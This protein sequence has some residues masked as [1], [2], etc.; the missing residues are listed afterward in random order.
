MR[1][2][3]LPHLVARPSL[4]SAVGLASIT[5]NVSRIIGPALGAWLL[6]SVSTAAA[7]LLVS[8]LFGIGCLFL[9]RLR[10]RVQRSSQPKESIWGALS[11]GLV[12]I[13]RSPI[14]RL[15]L[16]LTTIDG[17]IGRS[18]MELLPA[19]SGQ[20]I[21]G[22]AGTLASLSAVAGLG[23]VL[24]GL[25][26][27]RMRGRERT[28]LQLVFGSLLLCSVVV[29]LVPWVQGGLGLGSM[30][31][32]VSMAVT[33]TGTGCQALIQGSVADAFRG[34]VLSIWTVVSLGIPAL[35]ALVIGSVAEAVGFPLVLVI[36]ALAAGALV[37]LLL[38]RCWATMVLRK[39]SMASEAAG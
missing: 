15:V 21:N 10:V 39:D 17:L 4:P 11:G 34:R 29:L 2:V 16:I 27:S 6:V 5:Y 31:M 33:V 20:L 38:Q 30:I 18:I 23:S 12:V 28:L 35:G 25:L 32:L 24:G 1:L 3:L 14:I 19:I 37:L 9:L 13:R 36:C 26:V 8:A 7:F 22:D